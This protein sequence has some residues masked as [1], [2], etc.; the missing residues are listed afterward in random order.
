MAGRRQGNTRPRAR[1]F[2]I[3][4]LAAIICLTLVAIPAFAE[5]G[6]EGIPLPP[7]P[8]A[9]SGEVDAD[10]GSAAGYPNATPGQAASLFTSNFSATVDSLSSDPADLSG[11]HLAFLN[12]HAA[13]VSPSGTDQDI[14][15]E[16][17]AILDRDRHDPEVAQSDLDALLESQ[18][19]DGANATQLV[20]STLPLR[21]ST[22]GADAPVDLSLDPQSSG[23]TP[24]NPLVDLKLPED[25]SGDVAVGNQGIKV[26]FD[27]SGSANADRIAGDNL[28]YADAAPA[29]DVVLAPVSPGLET[30]YQLRA[31]ESPDSFRIDFTLPAGAQLTAGGGGA[32]VVRDGETLASVY[33]PAA[34]DAAGSPV[35]VTMSIEGDSLVLGVPHSDPDIRYPIS[36]DPVIDTYTWSSNGAGQFT[37]WVANQTAGSPYQLR[38]TCLQSVTCSSGTSG[39]TGLYSLLPPSQS[40][41]A[42]STGAWQYSVPHFPSTSAFISALSMGPMT[43][44]NRTD[45]AT[46]PFMFAGVYNDATGSYLA[47]QSWNASASNLYWSFDAALGQTGGRKAVFNL[48]SFVAKT[49]TAWRSAYLGG[50][51]V[52]LGDTDAPTLSMSHTGI[53][54]DP[55]TGY[56]NWVDDVTPSVTVSATDDGLGIRDVVT[57]TDDGDIGYVASN[58]CDGTNAAPCPQHPAAVTETYDT[59]QMMDGAITTGVVAEDAVGK[60]AAQTFVLRV[61]H[62]PPEFV[63][64]GSLTQGAGSGPYSLHVDSI[65]GDASADSEPGDW[66]SGVKRINVFVNG[67]LVKTS[68][69]QT[70]TADAGSCPMSTD[71]TLDPS[72]FATNNLHVKVAVTDQLDHTATQEWDTTISGANSQPR[73]DLSGEL[74]NAPSGWVDQLHTYQLPVS[75]QDAAGAT[76]LQLLIDGQQI[77]EAAQSCVGGGCT[78]SRTFTVNPANYAGGSHT[79]KVIAGDAS[80]SGAVASWTMNVNPAG[81]ISASEAASTLRAADATSDLNTVASPQEVLPAAEINSGYD[82]ALAQSGDDLTSTGTPTLSAMSTSVGTGF[83]IQAPDRSYSATPTQ[84]AGTTTS[85]TIAGTNAAVWANVRS[86]VDAVV[87]PIYDGDTTSASIRSASSP[88]A[89]SWQVGLGSGQT[90]QSTSSQSAEV[91][92]SDGSP[93]MLI[94]SANALDATGAEVPTTVSVSGHTVTMTIAHQ[95]G[96]FVYPVV[97]FADWETGFIPPGFDDGGTTELDGHVTPSVAPAPEIDTTEPAMLS[98][99]LLPGGHRREWHRRPFSNKTCASPPFGCNDWDTFLKGYYHYNGHPYRTGG[100]AF[101]SPHDKQS[102]VC[103]TDDLPTGLVVDNVRNNYGWNGGRKARYSGGYGEGDHLTA[104][105]NYSVSRGGPPHPVIPKCKNQRNY[106]ELYGDGYYLK[107][108]K[109]VD[110]GDC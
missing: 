66:E 49:L 50:A 72:E 81:T 57:P 48:W 24:D 7:A 19:T 87:S 17:A 5:Q 9:G 3:V 60:A 86:G 109:E 14:S 82:P 36:V 28:F 103:H 38:T 58:N 41:A 33:P 8:P 107:F 11:Q 67:S 45:A 62:S 95:G 56:S 47:S 12:D 39:P 100:Y 97:G 98:N 106:I 44:N 53:S 10:G 25:L 1:R 21:T 70:C 73:L 88:Q 104:F 83:T 23:Y 26:N 102:L 91:Y 34:T 85:A 75:A 15:G 96:G 37:D 22:D 74:F 27:T 32:A 93:A 80:G 30:F 16:I 18:A 89:F 78:L 79:V 59:G 90:L 51:A 110:H 35:D 52:T 105:C 68:G 99:G 92:N 54:F 29:T 42:Q 2:A 101:K 43:L 108:N 46:N 40:V 94:S 69:N 77:D 71:Y 84:V 13:L 20:S 55:T 76:Q 64:T 4:A 6:T 61:D 31:P 65:D 63:P